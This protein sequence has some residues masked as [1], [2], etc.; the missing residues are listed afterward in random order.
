MINADK[1]AEESCKQS[2]ESWEI[3]NYCYLKPVILII[4]YA[5]TDTWN[6]Y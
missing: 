1:T 2:S 5:A 3:A 4:Y 6:R